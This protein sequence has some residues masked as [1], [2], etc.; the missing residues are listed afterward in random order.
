[1][2]GTG[3]RDQSEKEGRTG[4]R[5]SNA[6]QSAAPLG[7][8]PIWLHFHRPR[9]SVRPWQRTKR[10]WG[11]RRSAGSLDVGVGWNGAKAG[12]RVRGGQSKSE[13]AN[14]RGKRRTNCA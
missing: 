13:R 2:R 3:G 6:S 4:F 5:V 12:E 8:M 11:R 7:M 1:M 10:I 9:A 14:A